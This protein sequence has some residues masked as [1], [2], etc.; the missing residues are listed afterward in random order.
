MKKHINLILNNNLLFYLGLINFHHNNKSKEIYDNKGNNIGIFICICE[1]NR[2]EFLEGMKNSYINNNCQFQQ[3][4]EQKLINIEMIP[5]IDS[6]LVC[7]NFFNEFK[8]ELI[9]YSQNINNKKAKLFVD[10][11]KIFGWKYSDSEINAI[12]D[13]LKNNNIQNT[14]YTIFDLL[15]KEFFENHHI[16]NNCENDDYDENIIKN[17]FF[18]KNKNSSVIQ[19]YFFGVREIKKNCLKCSLI[20]YNFE[21]YKYLKINLNNEK[22]TIILSNEIFIENEEKI[23]NC[24]FCSSKTNF[25]IE[26][27]LT[28]YSKILIAILEGNDFGKFSIQNNF[29]ISINNNI[30]YNLICFIELNSNIVY[31]KDNNNNWYKYLEYNNSEAVLNFNNVYPRILFYSFNNINNEN[32]HNN[33]NIHNINNQLNFN[34]MKNNLNMNINNINNMNYENNTNININNINIPNKMNNNVN[35]SDNNNNNINI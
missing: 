31:Y 3:I 7:L 29:Y 32:I 19:R 2:S 24:K 8:N 6:I 5:K 25:K 12:Y 20:T 11:F 13:L 34:I 33:Q 22:N 23:E 21:H 10:F 27:I 26:K 4:R 18:E 17:K 30:L 1:S 35:I 9:L 14:L 16:D 28:N 15:E